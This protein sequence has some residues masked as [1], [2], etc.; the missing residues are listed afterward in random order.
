[1]ASEE[2]V[3]AVAVASRVGRRAAALSRAR[4]G[5]VSRS[6]AGQ[7]PTFDRAYLT[8]E[9]TQIALVTGA[10]VV[11]LLVLWLVMR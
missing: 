1:M 7:L 8:R 11:V 10:L 2:T 9:L 6:A 3:E 5:G 4:D